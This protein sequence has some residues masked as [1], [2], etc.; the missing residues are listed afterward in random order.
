MADIDAGATASGAGL[1]PERCSGDHRYRESV[2]RCATMQ[3]AS[4]EQHPRAATIALDALR[5]LLRETRASR[6][7][8]MICAQD[9]ADWLQGPGRQAFEETKDRL[10]GFLKLTP[11]LEFGLDQ[12]EIGPTPR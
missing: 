6:N 4:V 2:S 12:I 1:D 3:D 10:G 11:D 7:R 8:M 5:R 9:V